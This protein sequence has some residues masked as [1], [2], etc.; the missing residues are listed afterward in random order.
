MIQPLTAGLRSRRAAPST[1]R[2]ARCPPSSGASGNRFRIPTCRLMTATRNTKASHAAAAASPEACAMPSGPIIVFGERR[3]VTSRPTTSKVWRRHLPGPARAP[4][5][6]ARA[7]PNF[8]TPASAP[9][10]D[11]GPAPVSLGVIGSSST[12]AVAPDRG[13]SPRAAGRARRRSAGSPRRSGRPAVDRED[14]VVGRSPAGL[15]RLAL[16]HLADAHQ[17]VDADR[18]DLLRRGRPRAQR[19]VALL[20]RAPRTRSAQLRVR[21]QQDVVLRVAPRWAGLAVDRQDLVAR[22]EA[23]PSRPASP[24]STAP[25]IGRS[26]RLPARPKPTM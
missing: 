22:R 18:P 14:R 8:L 20:R 23:R 3:A 2:I 1:A 7:G 12:L 21:A 9:M 17:R 16:E 5:A 24:A 25:M 15:G 6:T 11:L 19:H 4:R 10:P 26:K 13:S